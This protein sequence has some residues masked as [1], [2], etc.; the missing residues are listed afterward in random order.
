VAPEGGR[1]AL[2]RDVER[3]V[4]LAR[5]AHPKASASD[6]SRRRLPHNCFPPLAPAA[7]A[8]AACCALGV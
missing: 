2:L 8:D 5:P 6:L 7:V 1:T 3:R 4:P